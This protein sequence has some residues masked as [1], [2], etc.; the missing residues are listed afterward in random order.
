MAT[1]SGA[2]REGCRGVQTPEAAGTLRDTEA[3]QP[4]L[5]GGLDFTCRAELRGRALSWGC[6]KDRSRGGMEAVSE[7]LEAE[8]CRQGSWASF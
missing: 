8:Y 2:R 6:L 3:E 1:D 5:G 7:S 4:L